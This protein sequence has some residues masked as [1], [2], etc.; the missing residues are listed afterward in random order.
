MAGPNKVI[1]RQT[2]TTE[3][4]ARDLGMQLAGDYAENVAAVLL[5]LAQEVE[6]WDNKTGWPLQC[7]MI[8]DKLSDEECGDI[9]RVLDPLVE[10]LR[11]IPR[12]R[13]AEAGN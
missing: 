2:A 5:V 3:L 1:I 11:A 9:A 12:E 8:C 13:V 6:S 10:H 7:R 4:T